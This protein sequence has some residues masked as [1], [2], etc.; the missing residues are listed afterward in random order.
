MGLDDGRHQPVH[1]PA[2]MRRQGH[3]RCAAQLGQLAVRQ[4]RQLGQTRLGVFFQ[5][6][7]RGHID[8]G[9]ALALDQIGQLQVL[10]VKGIVLV[11]HQHDHL[12]KGDG[13]D[14]VGDRQLLQLL[15][16]AGLAA[17]A[18]RVDQPD[19]TPLIFPVDRDR[20]AGDA[21]FR[22]GQHAILTDQ[23]VDQGRLAGI[24]ATDDGDAD[25]LVGVV[26]F[27][28]DEGFLPG[29]SHKGGIQVRHPLTVLG[30]KR[31]RLAK[32][33]GMRLADA[34]TAF[35]ALGLV[36]DQ[37]DGLGLT[38]KAFG[39]DPVQ[40][41]HAFA[42][43]DHE[44]DQ[45]AVGNR[46]LGLFAHARFQTVVA[47]VLEPGRVDQG[48]FKVAE[49]AL[50]IATITRNPRPV[51]DQGQAFSNQPIEQGGLAHIGAADNGEFQGH[52]GV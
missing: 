48:Q 50:G 46:R 36:G 6:P 26:L 41:G 40:R 15:L 33:Q 5:V 23:P 42:G 30:R 28:G 18:G 31:H 20:V 43:V 38:P 39:K 3:E 13:A 51:I 35:P 4:S 2:R 29:S 17:H 11:H 49:T 10:D 12:G 19:V 21:G 1:A 34:T 22:T 9:P 44:Q 7:L 16:H 8:N 27:V 32:A 14:G 25:R 47:D 52:S 45:V 24:G 37:H